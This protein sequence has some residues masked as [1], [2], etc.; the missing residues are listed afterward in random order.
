MFFR[1]FV[2][3]RILQDFF[4]IIIR[5]LRYVSMG[6]ALIGLFHRFVYRFLWFFYT[7]SVDFSM[8]FQVGFPNSSAN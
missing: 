1:G 6:F 5:V 7:F 2:F 4:K 3:I 8:F